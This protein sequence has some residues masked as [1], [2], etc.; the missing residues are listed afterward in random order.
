M[1]AFFSTSCP[2]R[3]TQVEQCFQDAPGDVHLLSVGARHQHAPQGVELEIA[4]FVDEVWL[5]GLHA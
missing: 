2:G 1:S 3:S 5:L 4:E